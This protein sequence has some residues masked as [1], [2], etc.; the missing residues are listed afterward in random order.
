MHG[1]QMLSVSDE[2]LKRISEIIIEE[3]CQRMPISRQALFSG[4]SYGRRRTACMYLF[5]LHQAHMGLDIADLRE[6]FSKK[7]T[8]VYMIVKALPLHDSNHPQ[9]IKVLC[10]YNEISEAVKARIEKI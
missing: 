6:M 9:D 5:C 3:V 7:Y 2:K 1:L 4:N 10:K 8:T